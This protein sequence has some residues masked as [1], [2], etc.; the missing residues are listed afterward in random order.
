MALGGKKKSKG[1][2]KGKKKNNEDRRYVGSIWENDGDNGTFLSMSVDNRDPDDEYYK[3]KLI[4]FDAEKEQYF[5]VK[6]MSVF[7]AQKG[8][9]NLTNKLVLDLDN[10]YHVEE[11]DS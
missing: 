4:W 7:E 8:P 9:R 6:S 2:G 11:M 1:K 5:E 3:G 10:E